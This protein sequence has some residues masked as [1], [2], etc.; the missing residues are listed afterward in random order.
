MYE[1]E[2]ADEFLK[3]GRESS[4]YQIQKENYEKFQDILIEDSPA[5]FLY[6]PDYLYLTRNNIKGIELEIII[7][8][9]KRFSDIDNWYIE[10][11]RKRKSSK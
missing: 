6:S 7:N 1:N 8:P 4:D 10:T 5:V 11:K 3:E 9:S 2:E